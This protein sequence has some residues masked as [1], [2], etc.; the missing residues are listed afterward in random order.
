MGVCNLID[1]ILIYLIF[2]YLYERGA[3]VRGALTSYF[4]TYQHNNHS[5]QLVKYF[6]PQ[7]FTQ[8]RKMGELRLVP[9]IQTTDE[10]H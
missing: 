8:T 9:N 2:L 6:T 7:H 5:S 3:R 4:A 1:D 10:L